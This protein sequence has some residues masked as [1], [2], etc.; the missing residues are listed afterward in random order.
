MNCF[1]K[2]VYFSKIYGHEWIPVNGKIWWYRDMRYPGI[3]CIDE[4]S[5]GPRVLGRHNQVQILFI[6]LEICTVALIFLRSLLGIFCRIQ[7]VPKNF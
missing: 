7:H 6:F 5:T 1:D 2:F 4:L 3:T